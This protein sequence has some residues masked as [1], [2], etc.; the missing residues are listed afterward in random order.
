M[1]GTRTSAQNNGIVFPLD[2]KGKRSTTVFGKQIVAA[3]LRPVDA[4]LADSVLREKNWRKEYRDYFVNMTALSLESAENAHTIARAGLDAVYDSFEFVRDTVTLPLNDAMQQFSRPYYHTAVI[5]GNSSR[6]P[7][8]VPYKGKRLSGEALSAQ[9]KEWLGRGIIEPSHLAAIERLNQH[10]EWL[11][12]TKNAYVLMGAGAEIGPYRVLLHLGATVVA[13]DLNRPKI[14]EKLIAAARDSAGTLILP[15][16]IAPTDGMSDSELASIAGANLITHTPEVATWLK[17]LDRP[18]TLGGYAYLDSGAFVR[19]A[20]AMDAVIKKVSAGDPRMSL[21]FL[22]TPTDVMGV[23]Q[24]AA[25]ESQMR[26]ERST[27]GKVMRSLS[28]SRWFAPNVR[29]TVN[30]R[31]GRRYGVVNSLITQQGPNYTLA[32]RI[33]R[34]RSIVAREQG[35]IVSCNVAPATYTY[36]VTKNKIFMAGYAGAEKFGVEI[37]RPSTTNTMMT[38]MLLHDLH[39]TGS[40]SHP[41]VELSNPEELF[42]EGANHG[43]MWRMPNQLS[44]LLEPGVVVGYVRNL[45]NRSD[46]E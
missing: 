7:F 5:Q 20:M 46:S 40:A 8:T 36:S 23:P 16:Q 38:A 44:S 14:W 24:A 45:F 4:A 15:T 29:Q 25:D 42:M 33:Q 43:G 39:Y 19:V 22:L 17:E 31:E 27:G 9:L 2:K 10:P 41:D 18:L 12:D 37:F 30:S 1:T 13:V 21:A 6:R 34:W 11:D 3:A 32:K 26:E 35:H 28:G